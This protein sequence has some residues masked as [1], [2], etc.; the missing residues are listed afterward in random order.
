MVN[1][2]VYNSIRDSTSWRTGLLYRLF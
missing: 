1:K 2:D